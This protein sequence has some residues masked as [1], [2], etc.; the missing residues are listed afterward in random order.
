MNWWSNFARRCMQFIRKWGTRKRPSDFETSRRTTAV[1]PTLTSATL[2]CV[3]AEPGHWVG[4][5]KV[6][7]A[8][9]HS[10]KIEHLVTGREYE[11]HASRLKCYADGDL[12]T[13]TE[14]LELVSS[15][16]MLLG[17]EQFLDHCFNEEFKR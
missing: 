15:E 16:G 9:L 5:F 7:A 4:P 2:C 1:Q 13:T 17:V 3:V 14:L 8:L 6:V 12:N 11:V 10:F